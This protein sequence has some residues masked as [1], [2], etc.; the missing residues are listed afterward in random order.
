MQGQ[1]PGWVLGQGSSRVTLR[2]GSAG[3]SSFGM[4]VK[5]NERCLLSQKAHRK[6]GSAAFLF[7]YRFLEPVGGLGLHSE[8]RGT[9]SRSLTAELARKEH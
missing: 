9:G 5:G 8:G 3:H 2:H 7:L 1:G 4:T 6:G